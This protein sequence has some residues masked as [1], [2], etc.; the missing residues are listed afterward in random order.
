MNEELLKQLL[1]NKTNDSSEI[2]IHLFEFCNLSCRFCGQDH[3]STV[4]F[5]TIKQK[6]FDVIDFMSKSSK[7]SHIINVMGGEIFNDLI[8]DRLLRDYD[9]FANIIYEN[10][11]ESGQEVLI[12]WVT[13]LI[14]KKVDRI[15]DFFEKLD[16]VGI[17]SNIST[18]YDFEGRGY[19]GNAN[20]LF[21]KNLEKFND[22]IYTIGF[23]LTKP[24][25]ENLLKDDDTFFRELYKKYTL[26]FDYYVPEET[27]CDELM[28]SDRELLSAFLFTARNFPEVYPVRDWIQN[29]ENKLTCYSLD[30]ITILPDGRKVT[31]RYLN[32][33]KDVFK[34]PIDYS[35]NE[36]IITTF[37]KENECITCEYFKRC[38]MRCFVQADWVNRKSMPAC[39]YKTFFKV[40]KEEGIGTNY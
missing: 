1:K 5:N 21:A 36:G 15:K 40:I 33:K 20:S 23:V 29:S 14:F 26:F 10:S 4:G 32:Y 8:E 11:V 7:N 18:S 31:C 25:I 30:K 17:K 6:A 16:E 3:S 38:S 2:E 22:R 19:A 9:T 37:I 27:N 13:N 35:T 12:N 34:T 28:P 24:S 39:L